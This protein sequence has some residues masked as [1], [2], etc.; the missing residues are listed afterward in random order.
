MSNNFII[1]LTTCT[2]VYHKH[3]QTIFEEKKKNFLSL[4]K[5]LALK[6]NRDYYVSLIPFIE[7]STEEQE[8]LL[9]IYSE[10]MQ[11]DVQKLFQSRKALRTVSRIESLL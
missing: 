5:M 7:Q 2:K 11:Q 3:M 9:D 8:D 10:V 4:L 6:H 1:N